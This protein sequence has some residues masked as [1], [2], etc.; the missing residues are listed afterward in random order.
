MKE[1]NV[2]NFYVACNKLKNVIRKG[3]KD[4]NVEKDRLES[5]AEHIYGVQM[6]AIAMYSEYQ[7]DID[8]EKVIIMLSIHELEEITIGDLTLFDIDPKEKEK[9]GHEAVMKILGNLIQKE[10]LLNLIFEFDE[11]KTKEAKFAFF[12]DKLEA[13]L[14][15]KIYDEENCVDLTHQKNNE[16]MNNP[17]VKSLLEE[18]KSFGQMWMEFGQNRYGYDENFKKLSDYAIKSQITKE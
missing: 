12:C 14:Q 2:I 6:L 1:K 15:S 9:I 8:I 5:V 3:W 17:Q 10:K 16:I 18:G 11:R 4:W 7:Y 13:D